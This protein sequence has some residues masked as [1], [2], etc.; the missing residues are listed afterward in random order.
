M[1]LNILIDGNSVAHANHGATKLTVGADQVQAVFGSLRSVQTLAANYAGANLLVLWDGRATWR[2]DIY[3]E[4]KGNR[5]AG[6]AKQQADKDAYKKQMP[7]L[8]RA[9]AV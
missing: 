6:N 3:P 4:Y 5:K 8:R 9:L 2:F 7:L 1:A